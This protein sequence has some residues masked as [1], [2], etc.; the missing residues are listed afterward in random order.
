[1]PSHLKYNLQRAVL[2]LEDLKEC[3][4]EIK[5]KNHSAELSSILTEQSM[6]VLGE[7]TTQKKLTKVLRGEGRK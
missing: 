3:V 2:Y 7:G 5:K 4:L 6:N 1:M